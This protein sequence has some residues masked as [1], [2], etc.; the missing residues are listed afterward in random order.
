MAR[1]VHDADAARAGDRRERPE[2][3]AGD[4]PAERGGWGCDAAWADDFHH[5]LRVLLTGDRDG[6]YA[7]FGSVAELAKAFHRPHVHDGG[8]SSFRQR[9]FG[10]PAED[11]PPER[12]VVFSP[13]PRPGRQPRLRRPPARARAAAR[14]VLH[15]SV[16]VHADAVHGRGVRRAGAVPVLLRPHR[17]EDRHATREGR[18]REF[19]AF[20]QFG[21]EVPDPQDAATFERSKLTWERDPELAALYAELLR[22]RRRL[23]PGDAEEIEFDE[24]ARWLRVRRGDFE[25]VCNFADGRRPYRARIRGRSLRRTAEPRVEDGHVALGPLAGALVA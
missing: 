3:P 13:E 7:E 9:R 2:R 10:A 5:A 18:R 1:R 4:A 25:L 15:A 12:F 20:A 23:P 11:V 24:D 21:E 8:Y 6:Y 19:A 14:C 16:A 17:Q 22:A